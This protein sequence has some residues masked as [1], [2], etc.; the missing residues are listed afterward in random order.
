[1]NKNNKKA[2]KHYLCGA[3]SAFSVVAAYK[4]YKSI[5]NKKQNAVD[6]SNNCGNSGHYYGTSSNSLHTIKFD[7]SKL[8]T[9]NSFQFAE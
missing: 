7:R 4:A 9:P 3:V 2:I 1:M 6:K 5:K 8:N